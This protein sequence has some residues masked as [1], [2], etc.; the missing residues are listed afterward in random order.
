MVDD[1]DETLE[2][3]QKNM[4]NVF[5]SIDETLGDAEENYGV[6]DSEAYDNEDEIDSGYE[7]GSRII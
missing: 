1:I 6:D 4:E 7:L 5:Q 2:V 3:R